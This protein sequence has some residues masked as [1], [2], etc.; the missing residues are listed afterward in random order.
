MKKLIIIIVLLAFALAVGATLQIL[1]E[2]LQSKVESV[3]SKLLPAKKALMKKQN[4]YIEKAK[5][6]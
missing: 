6:L 5:D 4:D 1:P 2:P 3:T